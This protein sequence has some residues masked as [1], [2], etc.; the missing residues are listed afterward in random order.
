MS[1]LFTMES[2]DENIEDVELEV[3]PE[4]GEAAAVQQ[5]V[6]A[7]VAEVTQMDSMVEDAVDAAD[8]LEDIEGQVEGSLEE[9]E[10]GLDVATVEAIQA[11]VASICKRLGASQHQFA[12]V[13]ATENFS[14][15]SSKRMNTTYAAES[16]SEFIKTL[17]E[18]IK[19]AVKNLWQKVVAM[20][21]KHVSSLG[22]LLK[23]FESAKKTVA[24]LKGTPTNE[25]VEAPAGLRNVFPTKGA[26]ALSTIE[27]YRTALSSSNV[28][29]YS[30]LIENLV[31][32]DVTGS[33]GLKSI[34]MKLRKAK[35]SEKYVLGTESNPV[36]GG[37]YFSWEV[38]LEEEDEDGVATFTL[39]IQEDH[40]DYTDGSDKN[41]LDV[42]GKEKLKQLLETGIKL[43]KDEVKRVEKSNSISKKVEN[44]MKSVDKAVNAI[45]DDKGTGA[46][47]EARN[48]L[49]AFNLVMSKGPALEA[50][51]ISVF[52]THMRGELAF[53]NA[54]VKNH[55]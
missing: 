29:T 44:F 50:K 25:I 26:I 14:S 46:R 20:F 28:L 40:G 47:T 35:A 5:E 38:K 12:P 31:E 37:K 23:A 55:K 41:Q 43:V 15:A 2:I 42:E 8:E 54:C 53:V 17:W 3:S 27:K 9:G 51:A 16:I 34:G 21:N 52:V 4:E 6:E 45:G 32:A 24:A 19:S 1:K 13:F 10:E 36:A 30:R 18:R 33:E 39:E 48:N 11:H 7:D 22:R 49:R